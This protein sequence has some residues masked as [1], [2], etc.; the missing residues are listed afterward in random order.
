MTEYHFTGTRP[1]I[2]HFVG[3]DH[4]NFF[5][6]NAKQAASYYC[7]RYGFEA[8]AY[9]GLETGNRDMATWAIRQ[10][11]IIF[12][13][14][15]P[16]NP[17]ENEASKQIAISGDFIRDVAFTV[18]D[19][20]A[21][22]KK[23]ISRGAV[24]VREPRTLKSDQHQ[25]EVIVATVKTYGNVHHTFVQRNGF[26]GPFLPGF[27]AVTTVDPVLPLLPA[28]K[29]DFIDHIVGNQADQQMLPAVEWY[30]KILDFHRFWSVDD[31]Q[32]YTEF[33]SLRSIVVTDY[34]EVVKMPINEP[35]KGLRK[36]QIQEYVEYHGGAG[37][38]H[39]ALNTDDILTA[40]VSL[41]KRGV[42]FLN[43]PAK[44]YVN[45]RERLKKSPV[46]IKEDL[47]RIE[48]LGILV[49]FDDKGYLL[50]L[51]TK[52]VEDRPTLFLEIDRKSVV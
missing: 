22:Y 49:D 24:S 1:E 15:S 17:V 28:T 13:F 37:V 40:I 16:L 47:A 11:K 20:E 46:V 9:A 41:R 8:F 48:E 23:A 35:A 34:D 6:S 50:Q 5:C 3:F 42:E 31:K 4:L 27:R 14:S 19:C 51:F 43:I 26:D 7:V 18:K 33:S 2:G 36:S 44:Y 38:Q 52:P 10:N 21:L 39:V 25:G 45:L 32:V 29:L 30:E 12:T